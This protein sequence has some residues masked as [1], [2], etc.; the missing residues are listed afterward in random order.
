MPVNSL[1]DFLA[2][3]SERGELFRVRKEVDPTTFEVPAIIRHVEEERGQ[4]VFFERLKGY[5]VAIASNVYGSVSRCAMALDLEPSQREI[6]LY[7]N[8]SRGSGV[9]MAGCTRRSYSQDENGFGE[10]VGTEWGVS[11]QNG[12]LKS[13]QTSDIEE[14]CR[15][16]QDHTHYLALCRGCRP[17]HNSGCMDN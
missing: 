13:F 2:K 1:R 6:E 12:L 17:V 9:G 3:L 11:D 7:K 4:A 15:Y 16:S 10:C 14:R 5:D 8:D